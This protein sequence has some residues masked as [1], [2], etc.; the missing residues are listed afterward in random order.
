MRLL[1]FFCLSFIALSSSAQV[2]SAINF[3]DAI[4]RARQEGKL[5]LLQYES[6][7]C[8]HC[9]EV[10]DKAFDN[11]VLAEQL[12]KTFVCVKIGANHPDR[13][14]IGNTYNVKN[15]FGSLF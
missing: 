6:A 13:Q 9:N 4:A 7:N 1:F 8:P 5:V 11:I 2:F 14:L 12:A 3:D 10:A 15:G